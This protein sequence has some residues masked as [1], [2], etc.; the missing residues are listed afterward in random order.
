MAD[1]IP[2][3]KMNWGYLLSLGPLYAGKESFLNGVAGACTSKTL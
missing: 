2:K 1:P 3:R